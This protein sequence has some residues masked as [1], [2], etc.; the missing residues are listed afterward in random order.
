[1]TEFVSWSDELSVGIEEI[2]E[3]HKVLVGLLNDLNRAI[4]EHHGNEACIEI[5]DRLVD[6]T[7]IHFAVEESLMRIFEYPDYENHKAEHEELVD[8]VMSMRR[9]VVEEGH[10]ISFKLLHFLKMWLTQHIMDSDKEYSE[11]FLSRGMKS[12]SGKS[13][14]FKRLWS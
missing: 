4:R 12:K 14:W 11:H 13:G 5:L 6:Y 2:D 1:M 10:K 7:R 8:E 9:E 3:Q